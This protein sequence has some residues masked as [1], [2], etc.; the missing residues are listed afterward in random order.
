MLFALSL[1]F[2]LVVIRFRLS[3]YAELLWSC[4]VTVLYGLMYRNLSRLQRMRTPILSMLDPN[5]N[6]FMFRGS[7]PLLDKIFVGA[8]LAS[9]L[10]ALASIVITIE[11]LVS[12]LPDR[13]W[14]IVVLAIAKIP[15]SIIWVVQLM[16]VAHWSVFL[17]EAGNAILADVELRERLSQS[18]DN[19]LRTLSKCCRQVNEFLRFEL[20]SL[21]VSHFLI[22][23]LL[24]VY[25]ARHG[26]PFS[27]AALLCSTYGIL[28]AFFASCNI[29]HSINHHIS[30]L[31]T[32]GYDT[33]ESA[34]NAAVLLTCLNRIT[35]HP[36]G[37]TIGPS[38][39]MVEMSLF[40]RISCLILSVGV[41]IFNTLA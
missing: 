5:V 2:Y 10:T 13:R 3:W 32:H 17:R 25:L 11:D 1:R 26:N 22:V 40:I 16:A 24:A 29:L 12:S 23:T 21:C 31:L 6:P 20:L 35:R 9:A 15:Q 36:F 27:Q 7:K 8:F 4:H 30:L 18:V 28:T 39:V 41:I 34:R 14:I 37:F 19:K 38:Q 33:E